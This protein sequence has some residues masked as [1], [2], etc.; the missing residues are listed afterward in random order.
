[1]V[2]Y[3]NILDTTIAIFY[4]RAPHYFP[5]LMTYGVA[6]IFFAYVLSN[7]SNLTR[8]HMFLLYFKCI[9]ILNL[10]DIKLLSSGIMVQNHVHIRPNERSCQKQYPGISCCLL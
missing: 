6:M 10:V 1:M 4:C 3:A 5:S 9:N 7:T 2:H 8:Y